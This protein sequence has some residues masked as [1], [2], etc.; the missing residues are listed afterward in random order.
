MNWL[1]ASMSPLFWTCST[2]RLT[3]VLHSSDMLGSSLNVHASGVSLLLPPSRT[4]LVSSP[5][6]RRSAHDHRPDV[7][8]HRV[9]AFSGRGW[10]RS[11]GD[12][13]RRRGR[14]REDGAVE[15]GN[16]CRRRSLVLCPC[17]PPRRFRDE[18][19]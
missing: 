4:V 1:A 11:G 19:R 6:A 15:G 2:K 13:A 16:T 10:P 14:D 12:N 8:A 18:P 7:R 9:G 17:L 3:T 5:D